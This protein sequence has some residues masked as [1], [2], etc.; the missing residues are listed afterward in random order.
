LLPRRLGE[1]DE[2]LVFSQIKAIKPKIGIEV[3]LYAMSSSQPGT[4][5]LLLIII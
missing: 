1:G 3:A 4:P 2:Y 5:D